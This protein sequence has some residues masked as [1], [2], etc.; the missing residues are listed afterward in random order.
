VCSSRAIW[1]QNL[2]T[3]RNHDCHDIFYPTIFYSSPFSQPSPVLLRPLI[4]RV[5]CK[6]SAPLL[7]REREQLSHVV[8]FHYYLLS[9]L[10]TPRQEIPIPLHSAM[11]LSSN[12]VAA[13][14]TQPPRENDLA[15]ILYN[16]HLCRYLNGFLFFRIL[17]LHLL[18]STAQPIP[19]NETKR[20]RIY[21]TSSSI[22]V[23][24]N[25]FL[26]TRHF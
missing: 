8:F 10:T 2:E 17:S 26:F 23:P 6:K 13:A 11:K 1:A 15:R 4:I 19:R 7:W 25:I 3:D 9:D 24:G 18:Y 16:T 21:L 20:N 22:G 5:M 12:Y 14:A